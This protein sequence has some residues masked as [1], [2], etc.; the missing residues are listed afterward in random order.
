M[1]RV[2]GALANGRGAAGL[3]GMPR[4]GDCSHRECGNRRTFRSHSGVGVARL[5]GHDDEE[6]TVE[7]PGIGP[8]RGSKI[9][10]WYRIMVY[11]FTIDHGL[12][13]AQLCDDIIV[14]ICH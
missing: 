6:S 14:A 13:V 9:G 8:I 11:I 2:R 3:S 4:V 7:A 10:S 1:R 12:V 5:K